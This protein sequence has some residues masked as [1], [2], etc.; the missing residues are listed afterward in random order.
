MTDTTAERIGSYYPTIYMTIAS[1]VVALAFENLFALLKAHEELWSRAGF[2][3][4]AQA[5][6]V[7]FIGVMFWYHSSLFSASMRRIFSLADAF[8]PFLVLFALNAMVASMERDHFALF[9]VLTGLNMATGPIVFRGWGRIYAAERN[10]PALVHVFRRAGHRALGL[11]IVNL[12]VG[13]GGAFG[14]VPEPVAA[15]IGISTIAVAIA[16]FL[17]AWERAWSEATGVQRE[18]IP[19]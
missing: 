7:V 9:F 18:R 12:S 2:L 6:M 8:N 1:I 13:M 10:Q 17:P 11:A 5:V 4:W 15:A 19:S 14:V 3:V 16:V